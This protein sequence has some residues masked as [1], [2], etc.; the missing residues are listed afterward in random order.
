M[1]LIS[2][3]LL[4]MLPSTLEVNGELHCKRNVAH[5]C[6]S[7]PAIDDEIFSLLIKQ[8]ITIK[9]VL[10]CFDRVEGSLCF[11]FRLHGIQF[12]CLLE[13]ILILGGKGR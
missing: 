2:G 4:V 8:S 13:L 10:R 5:S 9:C 7:T 11:Y 1:L 6:L 12:L 3:R